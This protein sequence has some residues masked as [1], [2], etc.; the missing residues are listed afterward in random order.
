MPKKVRLAFAALLITGSGAASAQEVVSAPYEPDSGNLTIRCGILIDGIA[1]Q[2]RTFQ[3][4]EIVAGRIDS[5][6]YGDDDVDLDLSA[7]TCMPGLIDTHTHIADLGPDASYASSDLSVYFTLTDSELRKVSRRNAER[8]LAAGFTTARNVG[9]YIGWSGRDLRDR[10]NRGEIVGPRMQVA[11]FYLTIPGGG[12]DLVIPGHDESE[13][14]ARIRLGVA[15][16]P[17]AFRD[18]AQDAIDGGADFLKIIASGAVLAYGGVPGAPEMTP[19]E[20]RAVVDV[21]HAA[22]IRV[23]AHAHGAQSIKD[24]IKAGVDSIE[25]ASLADDEAIKLAVENDVVFSMDV[26]NG[27]YIAT[28]GREQ[29]WSAEFIRK[30]DE[31]TEAQRRVF[32]QAHEAGVILTYGTDAGVYPHGDNAKQFAIMVQR[33]MTPM[34]AIKSA[35]SVAATAIRWEDDVGSIAEGRLGDLIA[36]RGDPLSDVSLLQDV[37]VVVKG[38]LLFKYEDKK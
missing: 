3:T 32:I 12:G 7:Y 4:V 35:T 34:E 8:T 26:Y 6:G 33:G 14:P 30:N 27:D 31:T 29:G 23:T 25:H 11:G 22:G 37:D 36:V 15:R 1:D 17:G 5:V 24:A 19:E 18:K 20:I 9:A 16:G 38:G 10:I 28:V 21:A 13:I 2:P